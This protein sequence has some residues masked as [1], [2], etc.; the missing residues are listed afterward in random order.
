MAGLRGCFLDTSVLVGGVVEMGP[1]SRA[2]QGVMAAVAEVARLAGAEVLVTE[3]RRHFTSLLRHGL[4]VLTAAEL[5][6]E[7][8]RR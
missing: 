4:R 2:A 8:P 5:L 1:P 3:S 6:A 7:L